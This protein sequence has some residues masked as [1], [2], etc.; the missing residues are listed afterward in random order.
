MMLVVMLRN[1]IF[2]LILQNYMYQHLED[3]LT[4]VNHY[5][6]SDMM[7]KNQD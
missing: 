3:L 4:L 5:F 6:S 1:V 2:F 7:L